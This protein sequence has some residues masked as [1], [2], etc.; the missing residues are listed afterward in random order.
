[1][2]DAVVV[3]T[4]HARWGQQVTALV[5]L[6]A[7]AAASEEDLRREAGVHVAAYKVPRRVLFVDEVVRSPS[8]KPDYRWAR[9]AAQ[10]RLDG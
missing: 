5:R 8:G 3:G 2:Y 6:R 7:G 10:A 1:V 4:P 9:D